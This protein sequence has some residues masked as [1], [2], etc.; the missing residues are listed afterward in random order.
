MTEPYLES[1]VY[2][3]TCVRACMRARARVCVWVY[4]CVGVNLL[5]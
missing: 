2:V 3:R 4:V 5:K 1:K